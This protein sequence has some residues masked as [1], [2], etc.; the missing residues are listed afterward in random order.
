MAGLFISMPKR[1]LGSFK[2]EADREFFSV[3]VQVIP[4]CCELRTRLLWVWSPLQGD[5]VVYPVE[6][7]NLKREHQLMRRQQN[8][9]RRIPS[10]LN[11]PFPKVSV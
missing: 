1:D 3:P 7:I 5:A 2:Y 11:I 10:D 6:P 9:A 4:V 8:V